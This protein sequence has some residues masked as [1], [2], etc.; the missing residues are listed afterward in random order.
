VL[1]CSPHSVKT[2]RQ[3]LWY[4]FAPQVAKWPNELCIWS[5]EKTYT[6]QETHD[7]AVQW[8]HFFLAQG[9]QPGDMVATYL[10]NSAD[11]LVI[12]L[13]LFSIGCAPAHLNYNLKGDALLHCLK[14][15]NVKL[16]VVDEEAECAARFEEAR[17]RVEEM[18]VKPFTRVQPPFQKTNSVKTSSAQTQHAFYILAEPQ[19]S[20][21]QE[22]SWLTD[23][24]SAALL[25]PHL[26]IRNLDQEATAGTV[27]CLFS[28]VL[29]D[30]R[31]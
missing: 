10:M 23:T 24:T 28:M 1:E 30:C 18:G 8:G 4:S 19:A 22:N 12:W 29:A 7:R 27:A 11:F 16:V 31:V 26:S 6:W 21:K 13:G 14:V 25:T 5:R 15:A 20:R 3:S 17:S 2:K 9:V